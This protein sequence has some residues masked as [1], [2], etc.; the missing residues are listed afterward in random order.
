M[1][2]AAITPQR[3]EALAEA[4]RL[5]KAIAIAAVARRNAATAINLAQCQLDAAEAAHATAVAAWDEAF[6]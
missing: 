2:S 1:A 4:R 6:N 5:A 3:A